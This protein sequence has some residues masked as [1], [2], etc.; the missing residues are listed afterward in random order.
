MGWLNK[1][2]NLDFS[3]SAAGEKTTPAEGGTGASGASARN[4]LKLV[5]MHD[6]TQ[7]SPAMMEKMR[8]ELVEVISRYVEIDREAL[9]INFESESNTIALVA[10]IP[11][12]ALTAVVAFLVGAS[13]CQAGVLSISSVA[14]DLGFPRKTVEGYFDLLE[15]LLLSF[16]LPVFRRRVKTSSMHRYS[17]RGFSA[18]SILMEKNRTNQRFS[19]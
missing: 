4:R 10:N 11:V 14:R 13:F 6:R 16:R 17:P 5:L 1:L 7:L 8:D 3:T 18:S 12:L 19:Q 2:F 9:D 15:D